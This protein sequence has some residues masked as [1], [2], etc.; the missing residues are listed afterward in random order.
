MKLHTNVNEG[1]TGLVFKK[2]IWKMDSR[3]ELSDEETRLLKAHPEIAKMTLATGTFGDNTEVECSVGM[4]V[5]GMQNSVFN[6]LGNQT[7]FEKSLREGCAGLK[8]HFE[9]LREVGTGPK[10]VEF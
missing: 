10:S 2:K 6:S 3:I 9:R 4:L 8:S 5:K 1:S 7:E